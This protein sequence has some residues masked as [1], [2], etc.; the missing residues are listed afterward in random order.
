M[1]TEEDEDY[2]CEA[3]FHCPECGGHHFGT[4]TSDKSKWMV[5]CHNEYGACGWRGVYANHVRND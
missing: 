3:A 4:N 5:T 1:M 2:C